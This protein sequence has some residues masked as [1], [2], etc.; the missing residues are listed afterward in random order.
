MFFMLATTIFLFVNSGAGSG[1]DF[2]NTSLYSED[3]L[4]LDY[5]YLSPYSAD[6]SKA[7]PSN[8]KFD[9]TKMILNFSIGRT[10]LPSGE[11]DERLIDF[12]I[13]YEISWLN[14]SQTEC[15]QSYKEEVINDILKYD[16]SPISY[17]LADL[18]KYGN[19]KSNISIMIETLN[20]VFIEGYKDNNNY[21]FEVPFCFF[22]PQ[23]LN[24]ENLCKLTPSFKC[25][26]SN[27][28]YSMLTVNSIN[29]NNQYTLKFELSNSSGY[30]EINFASVGFFNDDFTVI[31]FNHPSPYYIDTNTKNY[32]RVDIRDA[33]YANTNV[34]IKKQQTGG[35]KLRIT[36]LVATT[37]AP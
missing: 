30:Y 21:S 6:S 3:R 13:R 10:G 24:L 16:Y 8:V 28:Y 11:Y 27:S 19:C 17:S 36:A 34:A 35:C 9:Q 2:F 7:N 12:P 1:I 18:T 4:S 31:D 32:I 15:F 37:Q 22:Y 20:D 26:T 14:C 23:Y 33:K 29:S 5:V 25:T